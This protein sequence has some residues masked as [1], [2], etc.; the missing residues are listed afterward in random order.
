MYAIVDIETTG[1]HAA[2]HAITEIAIL[3]HDGQQV[4]D[5]FHTLIN[6]EREVPLYITA[7]TGI[8]TAMVASAPTFAEVSDQI[9][10]QLHDKI[11]VAH[12]VNFDYSFIKHALHGNGY[13]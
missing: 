7:L 11:F 13:T 2:S 6:P 3:V 10:Q 8:S 9:Y 5:Q 12:N 1:G 4:V